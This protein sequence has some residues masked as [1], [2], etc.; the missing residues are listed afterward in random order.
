MLVADLTG[1][2]TAFL[3]ASSIVGYP[4]DRSSAS[5]ALFFALSLPVWIG[6]ARVYGL[7]E[8]DEERTH[9]TT[10]DDFVGVLHLVTAGVWIVAMTSTLTGLVDPTVAQLSV[11][12]LLAI[13]LVC[14]C[15]VAARVISRRSISYLQNTIIVGAGDVGQTIARKLLHHPEY[16]LNVVGFV[17]SAPKERRSDLDHLTVL[18][19]LAELPEIVDLLD[20]ERVVVAFS[21]ES[22]RNLLTLIRRLKARNVQIDIVP[23]L[24][25]VVSPTV[26][27]HT[28]EG[29]PLIGL[30]RERLP[31]S[32]RLVKCTA[33][34]ALSFSALLVLSPLLLFV[35]IKIKLDSPGPVLFRQ[36]RIGENGKPFSILKFRTMALDA[37]SRKPDFMHLNR[38]ADTDPRMS[39]IPND[40]RVTEFGAFL[41][42][43]AIDELPQLINVLLGQMS[44]VGPRPLVIEEAKFVGAWA[45]RRLDLK[46]GITGLWQVHGR[47]QIPFEE[48]VMLDYL[49]VTNWS[50]LGDL[51]LLLRT[52]PVVLRGDASEHQAA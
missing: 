52:I 37:E 16:G 30:R 34:I 1:L 14:G 43:Y 49:Y 3:L 19:D 10:V 25:E 9:H 38:H 28:V 24:F 7:Y 45:Q 39:K 42:R 20:V 6:V 23:R 35:A 29:L 50:L 33:D 18:G 51:A 36:V 2:T 15:R 44:L 27:L 17:D 13:A 41:R 31:R 32:S 21:T 40:P 5:E 11:F 4:F 26:A 48:M 8:R 46:P 47:S 22:H 12:W